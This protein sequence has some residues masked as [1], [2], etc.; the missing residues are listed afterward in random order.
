MI[1]T[2]SIIVKWELY[3][4]F[5]FILYGC[6]LILKFYNRSMNDKMQQIENQAQK[7]KGISFLET[8]GAVLVKIVAFFFLFYRKLF[9]SQEY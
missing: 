6:N 9:K 3:K 1:V 4:K 2:M 7:P 5:S 8:L